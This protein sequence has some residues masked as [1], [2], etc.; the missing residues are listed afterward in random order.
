MLYLYTNSAFNLKLWCLETWGWK[1]V[2]N[3]YLSFCS[4]VYCKPEAY[5]AGTPRALRGPPPGPPRPSPGPP[6]PPRAPLQCRVCRCGS[7]ATAVSLNPILNSA[8][9]TVRHIW[10]PIILNSALCMNSAPPKHEKLCICRY[11]K[12][13]SA[14]KGCTGSYNL[15]ERHFWKKPITIHFSE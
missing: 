15:K 6:G 5:S 7:Y 4:T 9:Y 10:N 14:W 3:F 11:K 13:G 12:A 2:L 1:Q 8:S